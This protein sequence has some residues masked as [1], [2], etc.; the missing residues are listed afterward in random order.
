MMQINFQIFVRQVLLTTSRD[1]PKKTIS[2]PHHPVTSSP[3]G[4]AVAM[5]PA[6]SVVI[7]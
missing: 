2:Q 5:A 3:S 1:F 4:V 7:K 6:A